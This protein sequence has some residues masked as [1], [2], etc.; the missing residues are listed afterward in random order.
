MRAAAVTGAEADQTRP[1]WRDAVI[2]QIYIRSFA[3]GNG[4]GMGDIAGIRSRLRYLRDLG[5]DAI[6]IT[7]WYRSPQAD[8]GYDVADFRDIDPRFGTL[9]EAEQLIAE[10]H[11]HGIRVIPDLVP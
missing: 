3:D 9:A 1:W 4:D 2:Y 11:E 8:A 5:V 10:A 6:W 7:P